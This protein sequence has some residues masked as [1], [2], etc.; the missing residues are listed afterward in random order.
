MIYKT[1]NIIWTIAIAVAFLG[2]GTAQQSGDGLPLQKDA[3]I[4][5]GFG[6]HWLTA[7]QLIWEV[8]EGTARTELRYAQDAD[9]IV[10]SEAVQG[11]E[12]IELMPNGDLPEELADKL[13]HIADRPGF[14][15]DAS[16]DKITQALRGQMV[17]VAY[18]SNNRP[19]AA[20][21]VQHHGVLDDLF[22]YD[23]YLGPKYA[24]GNVYLRV[25]APT[26][27]K[28]SL[29]LYDT[30]KN[31]VEIVSP[32]AQSPAPGVYQFSGSS[33]WDRMFYR[34]HVK[35]YHYYEDSIL[36]YE[37][38]DPYSVSLSTDSQYSQFADLVG[39]DS[40]KPVGWDDIRKEL[41]RATDI[42]LYEAH[43]RDF[44]I[45]EESIPAEHRGTYMAFTHNGLHGRNISAG[46]NHLIELADAGLTHIHLL[47][48]NDIATVF[49]DKS[50]R[51][52]L[53]DPFYRICEVLDFEAFE[54][55]CEKYG[56]RVIRDVFTEM[57]SENPVTTEI[58]RFYSEPGRMN[59]MAWHDG[60]NWGYDPYH[61]NV[62]EGSY[63]TNP[64]GVQRI[65]EVREM[66]RALHE[67]GLKVVIDVVYNHTF[68]SGLDDY[69]VLDKIVPMY[70]HRLNPDS[71][72]METSTCCD[73]TAAEFL[74]M[75]KLIIDSVILWAQ[76]YKID[77]FRFDLMGHHPRYVMENLMDALAEL[78]LEEHGVDGKNIYVYGEGWNF[79]EVVNDRIFKQATQFNMGG[80][81]IGNFNDRS[82][83][84]IRGGNFTNNLR[85][86]GFGNGQFVFPNE[87]ANPD[88][89]EQ[90][91]SLLDG[92]DRIR[93][94][95][96]GNLATY[97]YIN[98]FGE[99][100]DG[101]NEW[102]GF[103]LNPQ[104]SVNYIDKHDNET[105][106]D[107]TQ[108][109]LPMDFNMDQRVR[110]HV[111]SNSFITLGLGVPFYQMGSD[112]LRSKSLD[113]NSFDSGDWY[114]AVDF[115]MNS[116]NWAI[117][118]PPAWDNQDRW[119]QMVPI[120]TNP[121]I[122]IE[123]EH[124]VAS[125]TQFREHLRIRYSSPLFRLD[126]AE[127]I[128][129]R[130]AYHNTGPEQIPGLIV[131]T[132]SD[133]VCAGESLDPNYDGILVIFN[134]DIN[135]HTLDLGLEGMELHPIQTNGS[136]EVVRAATSVNGAFTVPGL[137]TA[138]FVKPT[139]Q[140]QGEFVCNTF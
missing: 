88:R 60:F 63:S 21:N 22:F 112:I 12:A 2:C 118:L 133:G 124:M 35:V 46:M 77:S 120:L 125:N 140:T 43:V 17:V 5:S 7:D 129:T 18:D 95:M 54:E 110:V 75:E 24:D 74:M 27:Q 33:D 80:T 103:A 98:R 94:G 132:L 114:N 47:P 49:E 117:G 135:E 19:I 65:L 51:V 58:Q 61:F 36:E 11:G 126:D 97:P 138:V 45:I 139:G 122:N 34:F 130:L 104:E 53:T 70:Y 56:D 93:V 57:A 101:G 23:G 72:A 96:A 91:A 4:P 40:L 116:H 115:T 44:S 131:M 6:A 68:A 59:G 37:V 106:W 20:T 25:W 8:P 86:Q 108:T 121:N 92:A 62:P 67:I 38:T 137:T 30:D 31:L 102:I 13:R 83:D 14:F 81:N 127:D 84:G 39:D 90:L 76:H 15:V 48:I 42:T 123:R 111:L 69:S 85:H 134:A 66:V 105:L 100:V 3:S 107:N 16:T 29:K 55:D 52:D 9:I 78:T 32:D 41:P 64:E 113:R 1:R 71:G 87:E 50:K 119:E 82:R 128:H 89:A 26:A 10:T 73:N 99:K 28:I 109:K 79:G 136:D